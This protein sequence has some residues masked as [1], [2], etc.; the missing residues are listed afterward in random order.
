[1]KDG[2]HDENIE[3]LLGKSALSVIS[4]LKGEA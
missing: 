3:K 4:E 2:M 1:M